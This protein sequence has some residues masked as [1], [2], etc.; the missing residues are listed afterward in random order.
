MW[1]VKARERG[2]ATTA[3]EGSNWLRKQGRRVGTAAWGAAWRAEAGKEKRGRRPGMSEEELGV[4]V[5]EAREKGGA[6]TVEEG[7]NWLHTQGHGA[8]NAAWQAAWRAA[9]GKEKQVRRPGMSEEELGEWV[10]R[11][12]EEGRATTAKEGLNWLHTQGHGADNAAWQAAWR[13]A[14]G[15]EK[16]VLR[17]GIPGEELGVWV[18]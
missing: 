1:V 17:L 12:R 2:R 5:V 9:A 8:D 10:V 18:V 14:A 15:K 3:K 6:T 16:K 11:A 4:W 7:L 13:A